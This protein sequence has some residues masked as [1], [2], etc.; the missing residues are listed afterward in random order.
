MR[1]TIVAILFIVFG[2]AD[3]N[4][5]LND[6]GFYDVSYSDK[7]LLLSMN[8]HDATFVEN[9][10]LK[11][12]TTEIKEE[13]GIITLEYLIKEGTPWGYDS[14]GIG[15]DSWEFETVVKPENSC[16]FFLLLNRDGEGPEC[17]FV[18]ISNSKYQVTLETALD[19]AADFFTKGYQLYN[20]LQKDTC[21]TI[22]VRKT[23]YDMELYLDHRYVGNFPKESLKVKGQ[24]VYW[25]L[26]DI[27]KLKIY[28]AK[29]YL[30]SDYKDEFIATNPAA[31]LDGIDE[32]RKTPVLSED[33]K[34]NSNRWQELSRSFYPTSNEPG[35]KAGNLN[36]KKN[37]VVKTDII[38]F[39]NDFE[40]ETMINKSPD[41]GTIRIGC[42]SSGYYGG[43]EIGLWADRR[44][45]T[46][47]PPRHFVLEFDSFHRYE[48]G[49]YT[50]G[51]QVKIVVRKL[52]DVLY[53]FADDKFLTALYPCRNMGNGICFDKEAK[54]D[55]VKVRKIDKTTTP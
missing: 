45:Q 12:E 48:G 31:R 32:S 29:T 38:D 42:E 6:P 17:N 36:C 8:L 34:D 13:N 43:I 7:K 11:T 55:Y 40:V 25:G 10:T 52:D 28:S 5:Q 19:S 35:I 24:S 14:A 33:F 26:F 50:H 22:T 30:I 46:H 39:N 20:W 27:N 54:V 37:L 44:F 2:L 51:D 41:F 3:A 47:N 18:V 1:N 21:F 23:T 16:D 4:C 9:I 53:V 15:S 49:Y